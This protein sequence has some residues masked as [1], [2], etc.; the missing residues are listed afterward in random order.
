MAEKTDYDIGKSYEYDNTTHVELAQ[1]KL[2]E[3]RQDVSIDTEIERQLLKKID[4]RL[5]PILSL[6]YTMCLIDRTN[7]G[8]ARIAG[9]NEELDLDVG[10][11]VSIA[12]LVFYIGYVLVEL[13][14]NIL[15]R[16]VGPANWLSFL[17]LFWGVA[18][19]GIGF[20]QNWV[21]LTVLRVILGLFEGGL[22]PGCVYLL[23]S[24]YKAGE[25]QKRIAAFFLTASFLSSFSNIL[26]YGLVHISHDPFVSGWRWIF[27][28]EGALTSVIGL[29]SWFIV[30]DFPR[31]KRNKFL[32]AEETSIVEARL[33][34]E[35]GEDEGEKV[36]SKVILETVKDWK[37]WVLYVG[38]FLGQAASNTLVVTGV[39]WG[40]NNV[41]GDA[42]RAVATAIQVTVSAIGGIY[43]STVFRQQDAPNY[44]PGIIAILIMFALTAVVVPVA[45]FFMWRLNKEADAGQRVI[46]GLDWFRY[47]L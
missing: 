28:V 43:S 40:Q 2:D 10:E 31:S 26:A 33:L 44:L 22:F 12:L 21:T 35:R 45:S 47:T 14:S 13:P 5:L 7:I 27:I 19:L 38:A 1:S 20:S 23:G 8:A 39:A 41:R 30:I 17:G 46:E 3:A 34:L 16:R 25:L 32:T 6:L 29:L 11:R 36:N 37:V 24:W 18:T 15:I 9:I 42:K 4:M